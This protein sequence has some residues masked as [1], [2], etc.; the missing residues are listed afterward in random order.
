MAHH[1]HRGPRC[2]IQGLQLVDGRH[3]ADAQFHER[4]VLDLLDVLLELDL[5]DPFLFLAALDDLRNM[6]GCDVRGAVSNAKDV[7]AA[8][9]RYYADREESIEDIIGQLEESSGDAEANKRGFDLA[10]DAEQRAGETESIG[11]R[12]GIAAGSLMVAGIRAKAAWEVLGPIADDV[13]VS[14]PSVV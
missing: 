1:R 2:D 12:A 3:L 8:I 4:R 7:E 11:A 5:D 13:S 14:G 9:A 10:D 6:L